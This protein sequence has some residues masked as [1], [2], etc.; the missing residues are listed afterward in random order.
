V[1]LGLDTSVVLRL[2]VGQPADQAAAARQRLMQAHADGDQVIVIGTVLAEAYYGLVH[3]YKQEKDQARAIL[4]RM[5]SSGVVAADPQELSVALEPSGGA[6]M[7][8]RLIL[9]DY[10]ARQAVTL[11]YD[12]ALGAAGAVRIRVDA[13]NQS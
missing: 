9:N 1:K 3:H 12:H 13:S 11:T 7:V 5:I 8:D 10:R 4:L 6:G 2:L